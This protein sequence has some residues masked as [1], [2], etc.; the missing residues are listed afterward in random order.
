M[1]LRVK[2]L[3]V[4]PFLISSLLGAKPIFME[5]GGI[6]AIEA[7]STH[8]SFRKW[9]RKTDVANF[10]GECHLEFTGNSITNG[11]PHSP[12]R[13]Q[14]QI[15]KPGK[16]TLTLRARKRLES[17]RHD[18]SNDCYVAVKGDFEAGGKAPLKILKDD[19]KMFGGNPDSW[20]WTRQL[21]AHQK[22]KNMIS[23]FKKLPHTVIR[24]AGTTTKSPIPVIHVN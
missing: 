7:E 19:T 18:L 16:Y 5:K 3:L 13:Y 4:A 6:V 14:F 2:H 9:K 21:D 17:D 15:S 24:F 1:P 8:S 20:G 11:P 23:S 12:L 22:Y 10:S